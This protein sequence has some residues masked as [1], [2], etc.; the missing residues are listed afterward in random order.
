MLLIKGTDKTWKPFVQNWVNEIRKLTST[1]LWK[2][3]SGKNNPA[4]LPSRGLTHHLS[5][6][7]R[8]IL[9]RKGPDW[10]HD[11]NHDVNLEV[12][13]MTECLA[14]MRTEDQKTS[15]GLLAL[16]EIKIIVHLIVYFSVT[17]LVLKFC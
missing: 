10:L 9:W 3:C 5:Y 7:S 11:S 6:V 1:E 16:S 8:S 14:E 2:H 15:H 13:P 12:Q 17:S 4:D